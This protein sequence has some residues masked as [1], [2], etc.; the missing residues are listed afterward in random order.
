MSIRTEKVASLLKRVLAAPIN[1]LARESA[2]GL[3]T[4]TAVRLTPDLHL[5][6]VYISCYG[7]KITNTAFISVLEGKKGELRSLVGSQVRLRLTPD[8]RFYIDDTLDQ[9]DHIQKLIDIAK[10]DLP[11]KSDVSDESDNQDSTSI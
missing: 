5:A 7:G 1:E 6:K 2:A 8:L 4:V 3:V 10:K 9:I 11:E